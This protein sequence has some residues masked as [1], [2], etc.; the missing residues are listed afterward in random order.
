MS[1][2]I[3]V[4][5]SPISGPHMTPSGPTITISGCQSVS[6]KTYSGPR[7]SHTFTSNGSQIGTTNASSQSGPTMTPNVSR[8]SGPTLRM[9]AKVPKAAPRP[10]VVQHSLAPHTVTSPSPRCPIAISELA[11]VQV[12]D[13]DVYEAQYS[14]PDYECIFC[15]AYFHSFDHLHTHVSKVHGKYTFCRKC[16][17]YFRSSKIL[18]LHEAMCMTNGSPIQYHCNICTKSF[19]SKAFLGEHLRSVHTLKRS[20]H[21]DKQLIVLDPYDTL[22]ETLKDEFKRKTKN[23]VTVPCFIDCHSCKRQY[24]IEDYIETHLEQTARETQCHCPFCGTDPMVYYLEPIKYIFHIKSH[25]VND[26]QV[27]KCERCGVK[28]LSKYN[29]FT[30]MLHRHSEKCSRQD[31]VEEVPNTSTATLPK[32]TR[33]EI[34]ASE[35]TT[36][37]V[38][39][40]LNVP[41]ISSQTSDSSVNSEVDVSEYIVQVFA[42][43]SIVSSNID[44]KIVDESCE[45]LNNMGIS[46]DS[47]KN[48]GVSRDN[49]VDICKDNNNE[50]ETENFMIHCTVCS[51]DVPDTVYFESHIKACAK[52]N[53]F[54]CPL[55]GVEITCTSAE[56]F[57]SHLKIEMG[58]VRC[59][60]CNYIFF[61]CHNQALHLGNKHYSISMPPLCDV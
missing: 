40:N 43:A 33:I 12:R 26:M 19:I 60:K 10:T 49:N 6:T 36:T 48:M 20:K 29:G 1:G 4:A 35:I 15:H 16:K 21:D 34:Q 50:D 47:D 11:R 53:K 30:H 25:V 54:P 13:S 31:K 3:K 45:L 9:I 57:E 22:L 46:R 24:S 7:I 8:T 23:H 52:N 59:R 37:G 14:T 51:S 41:R 32:P 42:P 28:L 61:N 39:N 18:M 17:K 55:C 58:S 44:K 27:V 2:V 56:H 38:E 5:R